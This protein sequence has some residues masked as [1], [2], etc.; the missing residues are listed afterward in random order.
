M[1]SILFI[2]VY[3][4]T[5]SMRHNKRHIFYSTTQRN[6]ARRRPVYI[7][8]CDYS[9]KNNLFEQNR[10]THSEDIANSLLPKYPALVVQLQLLRSHV[11]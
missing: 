6:A 2:L 7:T 9:T 8:M 1:L 11:L 4:D 5:F 10:S 3:K